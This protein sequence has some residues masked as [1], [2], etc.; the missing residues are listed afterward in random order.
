M[1]TFILNNLYR[2]GSLVHKMYRGEE[3]IYKGVYEGNAISGISI[4]NL[5]WVTDVPVSGGTATSANCSYTIISHKY[6]GTTGDVTTEATVNGLLL[7]PSTTAETRESVGT[8]N[9]TATYSGFTSSS[10]VTAYQEAYIDYPTQHLTFKIVSAGTIVWKCRGNI[11]KTISYLLNDGISW[12]EITS[13]SGDSAPSIDVSVG[14]TIMFKGI[15][16]QYASGTGA[17]NYFSASSAFFNV[18]GNIMSLIDGDSFTASTS[19]TTLS[20]TYTFCGLFGV[21]NVINASNLVL[22]AT[23]LAQSCYYGMFS[24]CTSLTSAPTLLATTM[25]TSACTYMFRGCTGLTSAPTL[26]ATTLAQGCYSGMFGGCTE[27]LSAPDLSSATTLASGCCFNMFS[28]CTS[29]TTA[30]AILPVTTLADRC[31]AYMFRG[32]SSLTTA[33][34]L[35]ATACTI[36]CYQYMFSGCTSLTSAP[37]LPATV[38]NNYCYGDMFYKC[39]GLT[40]A[41]A[42]PATTLAQN[43]YQRMF[44]NCTGLTSAPALPATTLTNNC[45]QYMFSGCTSLSAI[46]CLATDI[47]ADGCTS[48]WVKGVA[49]RGT[50]TKASGV[51]WPS[52]SNGIPSGWTVQDAT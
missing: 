27:L 23:T 13:A 30:P 43:C 52:G 3:L 32:C 38:L 42:L 50:F 34:A 26:P 41:P 17:Y 16:T 2:N 40:N 48:N 20:D 39:I 46:T 37:A 28:G 12:T 51:S 14:D 24:G 9:L 15:N 25:A 1:S 8:L 6:N 31:Y 35:P 4:N 33:P 49:V 5:A 45:Y 10:S 22:P 11:A 36:N 18:Y 44:S 29:L 19:S 7:V 47:S 21:S